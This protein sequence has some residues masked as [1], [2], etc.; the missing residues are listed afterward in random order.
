MSKRPAGIPKGY[1]KLCRNQWC[2]ELRG[3]DVAYPWVSINLTKHGKLWDA[4]MQLVWARG[5]FFTK[6][7]DG[8]SPRAALSALRKD[9]AEKTK[10]L[11]QFPGR[12][13]T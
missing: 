6:V 13:G 9:V 2:Y 4:W 7:I 10:D 8:K 1:D 3:P 5:S 12:R 11:L